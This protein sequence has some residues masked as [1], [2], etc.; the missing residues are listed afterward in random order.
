MILV[1]G[2]SLGFLNRPQGK[3][4]EDL[5]LEAGEERVH[6]EGRNKSE[7]FLCLLLYNLCQLLR[8]ISAGADFT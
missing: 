8:A 1:T 7:L 2:N 5:Y 6:S 4:G 3:A